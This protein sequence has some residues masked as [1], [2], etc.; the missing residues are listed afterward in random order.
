[1]RKLYGNE[2]VAQFKPLSFL[3]LRE[4]WIDDGLCVATTNDCA[5]CMRN[6][7]KWGVSRELV[8]VQVHISLESVENLKPGRTRAKVKPV[9]EADV[10]AVLPFLPTPL[11]IVVQ[12]QLHLR[13]G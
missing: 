13:E 1:M 5:S 6:M 10:M 7:F 3:A 12:V 2:P 4:K 8:L 9:P 11:Q